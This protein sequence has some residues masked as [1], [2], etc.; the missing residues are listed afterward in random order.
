[1]TAS[2]VAQY[3]RGQWDLFENWRRG[4][5]SIARGDWDMLSKRIRAVE[6][7][8]PWRGLRVL[9]IGCGQR[10]KAILVYR[11][12][13]AQPTGIDL[14]PGRPDLPLL[15]YVT[16]SARHLGGERAV[17][18][19]VRRAFFDGAY[20]RELQRSV[21]RQLFGD[22]LDVRRMDAQ[23]LAFDHATFDLVTSD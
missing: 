5:R 6:S 14:E 2:G 12:F 1:M 16:W 4:V 7:I 19:L 23:Q 20:F 15:P 3:A 8:R 11:A 9:D 10:C 22:R 13:G 17:K 18:T 21:G